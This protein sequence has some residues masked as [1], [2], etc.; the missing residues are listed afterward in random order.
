MQ[1][2]VNT[3]GVAALPDFETFNPGSSL[4]CLRAIS[5][6]ASAE[7][8]P[9]VTWIARAIKLNELLIRQVKALDS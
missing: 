3:A 2:G 6:N 5:S 1:R 4:D 7:G 9:Q 8:K